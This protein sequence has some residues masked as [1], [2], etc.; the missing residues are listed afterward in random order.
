[1]NKATIQQIKSL[2]LRP[3]DIFE[4]LPGHL[5][6]SFDDG[7][8]SLCDPQ[9]PKTKLNVN[10]NSGGLLHRS[11]QH[12]GAEHVV[13]ACQ[14]KG[15]KTAQVL[16]ATCG[17]GIDSFLLHL[18]GFNVE[19]CEKH[20]I[21]YALLKDGLERL[22]RYNEGMAFKVHNGDSLN[23]ISESYYDVI[24]LDPMFPHNKKSAKNKLGMQLFQELYQNKPDNTQELIEKSFASN[25]QR[26]VIKRPT[27]AELVTTFKP[28][29][30]VIGKTC[31]FDAYQL[32]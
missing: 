13:K 3:N 24:Y 5:T 12:L 6:L 15:K 16:D 27:K 21:V 1:M 30:Q 28:T 20:S 17:L 11:Q 2:G 19:A 32:N 18:A 7:V 8:L 22:E 26:V 23:M 29:F 31:R 10:F 4:Q 14:I 9:T 25:C